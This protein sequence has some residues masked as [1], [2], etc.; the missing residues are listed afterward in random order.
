MGC[1]KARL[2]HWLQAQD[3]DRLGRC[4]LVKYQLEEQKDQLDQQ[5]C[6]QEQK[7]G[8]LEQVDQFG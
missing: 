5:E 2:W 1:R 4:K 8:R 6:C 3:E 7:D